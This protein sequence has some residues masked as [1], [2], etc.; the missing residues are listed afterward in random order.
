[1]PLAILCGALVFSQWPGQS[2]RIGMALIC[3]DGLFTVVAKQTR[4]KG[5]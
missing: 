3:S 5:M 2:S 1:M 4:R